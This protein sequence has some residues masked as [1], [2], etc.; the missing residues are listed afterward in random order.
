MYVYIQ[1][2]LLKQNCLHFWTREVT[3]EAKINSIKTRIYFSTYIAIKII[4]D[5]KMLNL[6]SVII[7]VAFILHYF[8]SLLFN[9]DHIL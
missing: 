8:L 4:N 6:C 3:R 7:K 1:F 2:A 5:K 9:N